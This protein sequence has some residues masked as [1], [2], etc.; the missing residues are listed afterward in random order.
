M[1]SPKDTP[2]QPG[3]PS[4]DEDRSGRIAACAAVLGVA[5]RGALQQ[6]RGLLE[7]VV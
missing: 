1:A 5:T 4:G 7:G 3:D 6:K 2:G